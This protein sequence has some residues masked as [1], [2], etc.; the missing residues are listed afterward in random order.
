MSP[1]KQKLNIK[2]IALLPL[3]IIKSSNFSKK[4]LKKKFFYKKK[5]NLIKKKK[6]LSV[7]YKIFSLNKHSFFYKLRR[8]IIKKFFKKK[9]HQNFLKLKLK[10]KQLHFLDDSLIRNITSKSIVGFEPSTSVLPMADKKKVKFFLSITLHANNIF[11]NLS[12]YLKKNIF[13][14]V[15][16]WSAGMFD[17]LCSKT[18]LK[19]AISVML[20]EVKM[21][22]KRLKLYTIKI[23]APKYLNKYIFKQLV[24]LL[25][26]PKFYIYSSF[27]IFNG[28]RS[29]KKRRKKRLK[30]RFFR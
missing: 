11:M 6:K 29:Q 15:K 26:K 22:L 20:K 1:I 19:F 14:T 28:C 8:K 21:Q 7:V 12:K 9:E 23:K 13:K 18:K 16:F 27:K 25:Y 30:F 5:F 2:G 24:R 10:L 4:L 17:F 3:K